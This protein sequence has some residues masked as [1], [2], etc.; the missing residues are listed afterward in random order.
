[1]RPHAAEVNLED[2]TY[3]VEKMDRTSVVLT[4]DVVAV[5]TIENDTYVVRDLDREDVVTIN[6][7]YSVIEG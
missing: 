6:D 3:I 2:T 4:E 7:V 1:M 5:I